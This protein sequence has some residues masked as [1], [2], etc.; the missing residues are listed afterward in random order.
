[1]G[2]QR[3]DILFIAGGEILHSEDDIAERERTIQ[4]Y[5]VTSSTAPAG[6]MGIQPKGIYIRVYRGC[7]ILFGHEDAAARTGVRCGPERENTAGGWISPWRGRGESRA[8][9][10][11]RARA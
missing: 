3:R 5:R 2:C 11:A 6:P 10:Q 4:H 1:M 7:W 9:S 8:C